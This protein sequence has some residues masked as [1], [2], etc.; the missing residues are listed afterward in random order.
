MENNNFNFE[1]VFFFSK[2]TVF[3]KFSEYKRVS[4]DRNIARARVCVCNEKKH[5]S[6]KCTALFKAMPTGFVLRD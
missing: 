4:C 5:V 3:K 2:Q 6:S 1:G